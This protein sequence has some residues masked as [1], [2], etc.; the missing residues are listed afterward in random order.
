MF[1]LERRLDYLLDWRMAI[2]CSPV[3]SIRKVYPLV[4]SSWSRGRLVTAFDAD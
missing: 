4:G 3:L 2:V 1:Y